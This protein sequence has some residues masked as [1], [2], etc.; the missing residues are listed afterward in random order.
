MSAATHSVAVLGGT[1]A[2]G[3]QISLA[4]LTEFKSN[5]H[6]V[7]VLTRDPSSAVAKELA[8]RGASLVKL[9]E[10]HLTRV[11]DDAFKDVDVV[12]N[13]LS[14]K[15]SDATNQAVIDAAARSNIKAYF[16]D[17]YGSDHWIN[18]FS[19]YEH[20]GWLE[21][22]R[23]ATETRKK[24]QGKKVIAVSK[25]QLKWNHVNIA[26]SLSVSYHNVGVDIE[27]NVYSVY[28]SPS[29]KFSTTAKTDVARSVARLAILALDPATAPKVPDNVRIA[30]ATVTYE[31]IRDI[32][33]RVKGVPKGEIKAEDL[34]QHKEDIRQ[35]PGE[36]F[37]D[38]LRVVIGEGKA[39]FSTTNANA[40][41]N[42]GEAFWKWTTVE[43][44]VRAL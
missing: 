39:D 35:H 22:Q 37:I 5:F 44:Y 32:V 31:E 24:L 4:F 30:G 6:T 11:L 16:L 2:L 26:N 10:S 34:Q 3:K 17:E 20:P 40:L 7:R 13:A 14:T 25:L 27:N 29:Q 42:P 28:G 1:G 36:N 43:E 19:G 23:I 8:E 9:D 38:Y 33:A 15:S 21:K 12:V 18:E 41:V